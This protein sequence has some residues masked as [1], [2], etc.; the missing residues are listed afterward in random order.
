MRH[1]AAWSGPRPASPSATIVGLTAKAAAGRGG[2]GG[3][4]GKKPAKGKAARPSNVASLAHLSRLPGAP[5]GA[6]SESGDAASYGR[7]AVALR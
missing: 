5:M 3:G 6:I 7:S 2:G 4:G 1:S